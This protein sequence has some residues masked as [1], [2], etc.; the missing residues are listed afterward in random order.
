MLICVAS[1]AFSFP[2]ALRTGAQSIG[3]NR[4]ARFFHHAG[5]MHAADPAHGLDSSLPFGGRGRVGGFSLHRI[6]GRSVRRGCH[7]INLQILEVRT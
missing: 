7:S 5:R 3:M 1:T 2:V 4:V 6:H